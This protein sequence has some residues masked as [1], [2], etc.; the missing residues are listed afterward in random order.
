MATATKPTEIDIYRAYMAEIRTRIAVVSEALAGRLEGA[1]E[2]LVNEV[3]FLQ[4]RKVLE[5]IAFASLAAHKEAYSTAHKSF[6]KHW[7]AKLILEALVKLNP[8]FFPVA[9][10]EP[11]EIAPGRK[12]FPRPV[13]G[14]LTKDDFVFLYDAASGVLH[15]RNPYTTK[16]PTIPVRYPVAKWVERIQRL[17]ALHHVQLVGGGLWIVQIPN[18]GDVLAWPADPLPGVA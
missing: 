1:P 2:F 4:L 14:F 9:M 13:D 18:E 10:D 16:D 8:D 12:H 3:I 6:A 5:L 11:R 17:L 7:K 15:T